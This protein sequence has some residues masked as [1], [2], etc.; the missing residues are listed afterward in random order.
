MRQ[1]LPT[2]DI[3]LGDFNIV[4]DEIDGLPSHT[5]STLLS[6]VLIIFK[7]NSSFRMAGIQLTQKLKVSPSC[8]RA[9]EYSLGLTTF[10][11]L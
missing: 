3:I 9:Q 8:K 1:G 6:Q 10:I 2:P 4:E 11:L 5:A 7:I